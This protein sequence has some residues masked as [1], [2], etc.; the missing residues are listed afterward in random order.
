MTVR[1]K[2][3]K[4]VRVDESSVPRPPCATCGAGAI[5]TMELEVRDLVLERDSGVG[6][7]PYWTPS[8]KNLLAS[9][10]IRLCGECVQNNVKVQTTVR[11][12][13]TKE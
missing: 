11:A 6:S 5:C 1:A 3:R 2:S 13:V 12:E 10:T 9:I 8:Y 4:R 7:V